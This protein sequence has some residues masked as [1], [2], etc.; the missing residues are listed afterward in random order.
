MLGCHA[1]VLSLIIMSHHLGL[2][3]PVKSYMHKDMLLPSNNH[4][5]LSMVGVVVTRE[6]NHTNLYSSFFLKFV[7]IIQLF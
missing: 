7:C 1:A 4:T 6:E 3:Y 2:L 5:H